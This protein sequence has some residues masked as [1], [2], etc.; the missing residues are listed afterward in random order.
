MQFGT[1]PIAMITIHI[2]NLIHFNLRLNF[3][4]NLSKGFKYS[5]PTVKSLNPKKKMLNIVSQGFLKKNN[6]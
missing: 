3:M 4:L 2:Q 1:C 6:K 5:S